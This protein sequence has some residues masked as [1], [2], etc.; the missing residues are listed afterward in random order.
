MKKVHYILIFWIFICVS[1]Q[2][3]KDVVSDTS[4]FEQTVFYKIFPSILDSIHYDRRL[5]PPP[6][7]PPEYLEERGYDVKSD[8]RKAYQ[9]WEKSKENKL[10]LIAWERKR[11]S[12][13]R[14]TSTIWLVIADSVSHVEKND[15][16]KFLEHF[17][18]VLSGTNS[19]HPS[20]SFKIDI[21][22][23]KTNHKKVEFKYISD[24]PKRKLS[25][26]QRYVNNI[27]ANLSFTKIWF[28]PSKTF[29]I[30]NAGYIRAPL[31][32][33]GVRIF[34]KKNEK[35]EWVI[36]KIVGTWIS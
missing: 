7:P 15:R 13:Q 9:E 20:H 34:I 21:T 8:Y 22:K 2:G 14:D 3:Q 26:E 32:G 36:D 6:P 30:L 28:D 5:I 1:I 23:L 11:D 27:H 19:L 18:E 29:G 17:R 4:D 12:I 10:R 24:Y 16:V 33:F 35:N 31:N 25:W